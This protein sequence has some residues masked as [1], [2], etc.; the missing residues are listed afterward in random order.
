MNTVFK[1]GLQAWQLFALAS[2]Y[3]GWYAG[4]ALWKADGWRVAPLPGKRLAT[5]GATMVAAL[6]LFGAGIFLVSGTAARQERRFASTPPTLNGLV[7]L[8]HGVYVEDLGDDNTANDVPIKLEDDWPLIDW[9]REN[10]QGSPV[11]VE[12]VGPLYHWTGRISENTG[13]PA[14]IGWDWHQIQQRTDYAGLVQERRSDTERFWKDPTIAGANNYLRKYNV[15][16]VV[17]GTE[18]RAYATP[19]AL[20]KLDIMPA[21]TQVFSVG[22]YRIYRVDQGKLPAPG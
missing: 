22:E 16:Y 11:I 12:A 20:A 8:P 6:L 5:Y 19:A 4:R 18:E 17:V 13:L 15:S 3:G 14:V 1:F 2:A 7:Y 21:L 9:L 10:V